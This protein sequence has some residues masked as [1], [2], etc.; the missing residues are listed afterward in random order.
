[1]ILDFVDYHRRGFKFSG[2]FCSSE[3]LTVAGWTIK[4]VRFDKGQCT[5]QVCMSS[6]F[7]FYFG[8][9]ER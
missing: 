6:P 9:Q 1:M 7:V 8:T 4:L 2:R 5:G 3:S